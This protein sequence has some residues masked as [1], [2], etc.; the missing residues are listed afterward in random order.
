MALT[1]LVGLLRGSWE[2]IYGKGDL[3]YQDL[4]GKRG[5][6]IPHINANQLINIHRIFN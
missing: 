3:V 6:L 4:E 5:Y 2:E 1:T